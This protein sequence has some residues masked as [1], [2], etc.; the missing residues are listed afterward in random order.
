MGRRSP[1]LIAVDRPNC[2]GKSPPGSPILRS[3]LLIA[4]LF[5]LGL[6]PAGCS[7]AEALSDDKPIE[8]AADSESRQIPVGL[9]NGYDGVVVITPEAEPGVDVSPGMLGNLRESIHRELGRRALKQSIPPVL[10]PDAVA[11]GTRAEIRTR[12]DAVERRERR[13]FRWFGRKVT[14]FSVHVSVRFVDAATEEPLD[15]WA[16]LGELIGPAE[17]RTLG[18]AMQEVTIQVGVHVSR[19]QRKL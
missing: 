7:R 17:G 9:L 18:A 1:P 12:I 11:R 2:R 16:D 15:D 5:S 6:W 14:D 13:R 3:L 8:P 4:A 19:D 10:A